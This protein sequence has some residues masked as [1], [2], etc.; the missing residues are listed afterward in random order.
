MN[1]RVTELAVEVSAGPG[2]ITSIVEHRLDGEHQW[3]VWLSETSVTVGLAIPQPVDCVL[4][5]RP[6]GGYRGSCLDDQGRPAGRLELRP[7]APGMLLPEHE[8]LLARSAAPARLR[9]GA[10]VYVLRDDGLHLARRGVNEVSCLVERPNPGD[11]WPICYRTE[12]ARRLIPVRMLESR[13]RA[14]GLATDAIA[15][16]I[17]LGYRSGRLQPLRHA[18]LAYMLSPFS[19]TRDQDTGETLWTSPRHLYFGAGF[20]LAARVAGDRGALMDW[21]RLSRGGTGGSIT[22]VPAPGL[23][24]AGDTLPLDSTTFDQAERHLRYQ[25]RHGLR[26]VEHLTA[27]AG[28]GD[29]LPMVV[30][31]HSYTGDDVTAA[32]DYANLDIPVR[33]IV[34][35]APYEAVSGYSWYRDG[36]YRAPL[37]AQVAEAQVAASMLAALIRDLQSTRPTRGKPIVTGYSQGGDLSYLL[38]VEYPDLVGGTIPMGGRLLSGGRSPSRSAAGPDGL[39]AIHIFHGALDSVVSAESARKAAAYLSGLGFPVQLSEFPDTG[40]EY[41]PAMKRAYADVVA[42][43]VGVGGPDR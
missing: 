27:G 36:H 21:V 41:P 29:T 19:W 20:R 37:R 8:L 6:R 22:A 1:G 25:R 13:L 16:S 5:V 10:T 28:T 35:V 34:P 31:L 7:P 23:A 15:D 4:G 24:S 43:L 3:S 12:S 26:F 42:R 11:L 14:A 9:S 17:T 38:A 33:V 40:H 18:D 39:P 30:A 32:I 2:G